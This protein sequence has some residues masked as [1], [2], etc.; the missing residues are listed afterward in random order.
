[1]STKHELVIQHIKSLPIGQKISV[2]GISKKLSVSEGTS[3]RAIKEAEQIG[4]VSTIDRVGT[5]RIEQNNQK[6]NPTYLTYRQIVPIIEGEILG[7]ETG[8]DRHLNRFIIGAMTLDQIEKYYLPNTLL[9]VGNRSNV[10]KQ[11]LE[12]NVAVLITG[13]FKPNDSMIALANQ[14]ELPI[15][16]SPFD[17]FTVASRINR[18]M[19]NQEIEK[20]IMT[21]KDVYIPIDKANSLVGSDSVRTFNQLT[22]STGV[23][24]F[25]VHYN[26]RLVGIVTAKDVIGKQEETLI[27]RVMTREVVTVRDYMTI[28]NVSH[29]MVR[30]DIEMLPVV[31]DNLEL[32]GVISRQD[33][34]RAMHSIENQPQ[35]SNTYEDEVIT[36]LNHLMVTDNENPYDFSITVQ[37]QML[38]S[39][40]TLSNGVLCELL[41]YIT[42]Q[43]IN[44]V[45]GYSSIIEKI[46][47]NSFNLIQLYNEIHFKVEIFHQNRRN[48]HAQIDI[49]YENSLCAKA[50]ITAQI[51]ESM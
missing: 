24:R 6:S 28:A 12:H 43:K 51:I 33:V 19:T 21:I 46:H 47:L 18:M 15:I 30:E 7:G 14:K 29:L 38:N 34:M 44:Y 11:A 31:A 23:S 2:R 8:V 37:P 26:K 50:I 1:M 35:Y 5:I 42:N 32:M 3:Y 40:G 49:F 13:G 16:T 9:I 36:H 41:S 48:A 17:T 27:E 4:L 39:Y 45:T 25:P 22:K 20:E 10:Q